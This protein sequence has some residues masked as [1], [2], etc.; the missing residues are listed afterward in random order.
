MARSLARR[1]R[2]HEGI[3]QFVDGRDQRPACL[4]EA[5]SRGLTLS[6]LADLGHSRQARVVSMQRRVITETRLEFVE[7]G[8]DVPD[9]VFYLGLISIQLLGRQTD[10]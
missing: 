3:R 2:H 4:I 10:R 5:V 1:E 8:A 6:R 7:P 9:A